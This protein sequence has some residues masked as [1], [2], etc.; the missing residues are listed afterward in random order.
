MSVY[1]TGCCYTA[2]SKLVARTKTNS[3]II[4]S[5]KIWEIGV[6]FGDGGI[7][8]RRCNVCTCM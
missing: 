3:I 6:S 5:E 4:S 7:E 8:E 2:Y 1:R